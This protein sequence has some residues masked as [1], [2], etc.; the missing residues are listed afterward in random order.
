MERDEAKAIL[1]LCRPGNQGDRNDPLIAQALDQLENDAELRAWF[2]EQQAVDSRISDSFGELQPDPA[3]KASILAGMRA[4]A[5]QNQSNS[6]SVEGAESLETGSAQRS[7]DHIFGGS[8]E[9]SGSRSQAWWR[10]PWIGIAAI[11]AVLFAMSL[12]PREPARAPLPGPAPFPISLVPREPASTQIASSDAQTQ[13]LQADVPALIRF[14]AA[15]IDAVT[16]NQR[17][18]AKQ[19]D[20]PA[21]LQAY[22]A[23]VGIPS[24]AS[25][26]PSI[27]KQPSL[28]CFTFEYNG[29]PVGMICFKEK[30]LIHLITARKTDC[31]GEFPD[32][33]S[34]YELQDQAFRVRVE[35]EQIQILSVHGSKEMLPDLI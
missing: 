5:L 34:V 11:F 20:Q 31:M 18:F 24:P 12:V 1:E 23:S 6:Q 17:S 22:L 15:E 10:N 28:G 9:V 13:P 21:T 33:P 16:S 25:L 35:G 8:G 4:H 3:L 2:D 26:P 29:N 7:P 19:S 32:H 14:L 30:Q 27:G